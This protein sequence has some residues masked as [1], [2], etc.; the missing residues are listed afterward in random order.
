MPTL[1]CF[2]VV[3]LSLHA[4]CILV[5]VYDVFCML[6][7]C[8]MATKHTLSP[9]STS[10]S[11]KQKKTIY[12]VTKIE[13][14]FW[15]D[16]GELAVDIIVALG[17][18]AVRIRTIYFNVDTIYSSIQCTMRVSSLV[19]CSHSDI[20]SKMEKMLAVQVQD[21]IVIFSGDKTT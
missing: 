8:I 19:S 18:P 5:L 11:K 12:L 4:Q 21:A 9:G 10:A 17:L 2:V 6:Y 1:I 3:G 14:L 7:N 20:M 16:A 15:F 13:G